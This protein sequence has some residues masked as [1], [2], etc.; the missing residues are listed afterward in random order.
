M[1]A[2]VPEHPGVRRSRR[3]LQAEVYIEAEGRRV[4]VELVDVSLS[5]ARLKRP[6]D[7]DATPAV[8]EL[9]LQAGEGELLR[10]T[11]TVVR[12]HS[13]VIALRFVDPGP[14]IG[15]R[16]ESLLEREGRLVQ[17]IESVE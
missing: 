9:E 11:A 7:W 15:A 13:E 3:R 10:I 6:R 8:V 4:P 5:G 12:D 17:G 2:D 14:R 16:L 1:S